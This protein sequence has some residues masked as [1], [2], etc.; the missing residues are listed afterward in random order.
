MVLSG[1]CTAD[2][3]PSGTTTGATATGTGGTMATDP[4][5]AG[6]TTGAATG[7]ESGGS[8]T[9][10]QDIGYSAVAIPGAPN[11]IHIRHRDDDNDR[12]TW[13]VLSDQEVGFLAI[14]TPPGWTPQVGLT[15]TNDFSCDEPDPIVGGS[16]EAIEGVGEIVEVE[17]GAA[18][19]CVLDVNAELTFSGPDFIEP[20]T[21]S[22]LTVDGC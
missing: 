2:D 9:G 7:T 8:S 5:S 13:I 18:F 6:D 21:V 1:G 15:N 11:R 22:G 16:V 14:A 17:A 3:L 20:F 10:E 19:P 4:T 12:C